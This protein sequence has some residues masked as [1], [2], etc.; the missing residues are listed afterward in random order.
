MRSITTLLAA[1]TLGLGLGGPGQASGVGGDGYTVRSGDSLGKIARRCGQSVDAILAANP[2]VKNP[3]HLKIGQDL[4][5]PGANRTVA[6]ETPGAEAVETV[7]KGRIFAG[8]WCA[9]IETKEGEVFGLASSRHSFRSDTI[10]E[11]K[12]RKI[13]DQECGQTY[14]IAVSDLSNAGLNF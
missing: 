13:A 1:T 6:A 9:L 14:T 4:A 12:G 3:R 8:R 11:V 2:E 10:V 7:L 5:M